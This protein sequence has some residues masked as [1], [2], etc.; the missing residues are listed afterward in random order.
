MCGKA[1]LIEYHTALS[2]LA[3]R[4][5]LAASR[6]PKSRAT[7]ESQRLS[8][9]QAAKPL[10]RAAVAN[11][12]RQHAIRAGNAAAQLAVPNHA[13]VDVMPTP[14]I[15]DQQSTLQRRFAGIV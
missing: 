15:R 7:T 11:H 13:R 3:A 4:L 5:S 10:L 12:I 2:S 8:A 6:Q 1:C 9:H 14:V